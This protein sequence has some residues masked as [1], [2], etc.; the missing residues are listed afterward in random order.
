VIRVPGATD[1][2]P[3]VGAVIFTFHR[4]RHTNCT[5]AYRASGNDIRVAQRSVRSTKIYTHPSDRGVLRAVNAIR[6]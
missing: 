3:M 6:F 4:L 5:N 1:A 2:W